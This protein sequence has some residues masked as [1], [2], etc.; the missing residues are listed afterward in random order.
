MI[1]PSLPIPPNLCAGPARIEAE[2]A[3]LRL[4]LHPIKSQIRRTRD[5]ASFV[6]FLVLPGRVR[7]RNHNLRKG[8][9]RLR[10]QRRAVISGRLSPQVARASL[11]SWNA[12]LAH[13][14]TLRLRR[15]LFR[16]LPYA[17]GLPG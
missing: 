5:G 16:D 1:S 9:R 17:D 3:A 7:L 15:R 8:I 14:H 2:L 13:G 12:H 11:Q 10:L 6:G 4:R